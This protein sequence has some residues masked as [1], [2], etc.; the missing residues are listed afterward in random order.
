MP[1][2]VYIRT[3]EHKKGMSAARRKTWADPNSKYYTEEF[4]KSRINAGDKNGNYGKPVT[5]KRKLKQ[6]ITMKKKRANP[7][8]IY[9]ST[10]WRQKMSI[11]H[12]DPKSIYQSQEYRNKISKANIGKKHSPKACE[13]HRQAVLGEKHPMWGKH[14]SEKT[15]EKLRKLSIHRRI[16][17][18]DTSIEIALQ[19]ELTSRK[20]KFTKNAK[21]LGRPDIFIEPNICIFCD[22]DYWH[23]NP[24][25]HNTDSIM[26]GKKLAKNIWM[27][28]WNVTLK[29]IEQNYFVMRFWETEINQDVKSIGKQI[30]N[31]LK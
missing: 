26:C 12:S 21:L 17:N 28:D 5:K 13:R 1:K 25:K 24:A 27:K 6:S 9:N 4:L 29:L 19:K 20:I 14:H 8:S 3:E 15:K 16:P 11:L 23:A 30:E 7:N 31:L 10:K 18:K 22:G 2:G